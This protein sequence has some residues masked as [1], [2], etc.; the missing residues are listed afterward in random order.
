MKPFGSGYRSV[1]KHLASAELG[2][3]AVFFVFVVIRIAIETVHFQKPVEKENFARSCHS[4]FR[5]RYQYLSRCTFKAC[6]FH[7]AGYRPAPYQVV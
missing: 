4:V 6:I 2:Q 7:L 1:C 3:C 5:L